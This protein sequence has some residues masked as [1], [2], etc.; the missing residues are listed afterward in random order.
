MPLDQLYQTT[1]LEHNRRPHG[2]KRLENATHSA[3]GHDALCGDDIEVEARVENGRIAAAG[4]TGEACA[5]TMAAASMLMAWAP[6]RTP[7][8]VRYTYTRFKHM[9]AQPEQAPHSSLSVFANL[10]AVGHFK[11]RVRNALLPWRTLLAA[12]ESEG[13]VDN[14]AREEYH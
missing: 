8:E 13:E 9:L 12:L 10:Q 3:R 1:I 7:A 11:S 2:R 6:G 14:V 4:F 5:V